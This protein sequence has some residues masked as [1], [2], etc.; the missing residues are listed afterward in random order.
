MKSYMITKKN[1]IFLLIVSVCTGIVFF[2]LTKRAATIPVEKIKITQTPAQIKNIVVLGKY[3]FVV[4]TVDTELTR[5][6]GLSG[7]MI[8]VEG[9]GM[10]FVFEKSFLWGIW[11]K[12]MNFSIDVVWFDAAGTIVGVKEHMT[13]ESFPEVFVPQLPAQYVLEIPDGAFAK[14]GAK[15]GDSVTIGIT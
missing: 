11:M 9:T 8:L 15:L 3:S 5:E 2:L 4:E 6:R 12:D 10:L 7:R 1:I 13:P 14:S